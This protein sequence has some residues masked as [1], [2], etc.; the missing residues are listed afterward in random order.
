MRKTVK[1]CKDRA[2]TEALARKLEADAML[3]REGVIDTR[4]EKLAR[5]ES[6]PLKDHLADFENVMRA[7]GVTP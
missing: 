2:A 5:S 6:L 1:G 3:R 7:R 4:A